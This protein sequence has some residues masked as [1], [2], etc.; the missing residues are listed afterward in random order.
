[1]MSYDIILI[2]ANSIG[3]AAMYQPNLARLAHDGESTAA[4]HGLPASVFKLMKRF[5]EAVP[6]ILW[7]GKARWRYDTYPDYKS[8][9]GSTPDKIA[10][11]EAYKRQ[12]PLLRQFFFDLGLPQVGHPDTEADDLAG[13]IARALVREHDD[14]HV[15][16]STTDSDWVQA[17]HARIHWFNTRDESITD[18]ARLASEEFKDGP[19][20]TPEQYLAAKCM[21]GDTSDTIDGVHGIGLKTGAKFLREHGSFEA[22]WAKADAG[23]AFK[24]AKL[25]SVITHDARA[26]YARNRS[27]MDW[28]KAPIP[29]D[30]GLACPAP[31]LASAI[32]MTERFG[33]KRVRESLATIVT[34][35]A[36]WQPL[37]W[38]IDVLLSH[39]HLE[40][41]EEAST[42]PTSS[43]P[44]F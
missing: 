6:V 43:R 17:L 3:Y 15:L 5:P 8:D 28:T 40:D 2:D 39:A 41:L 42:T 13:L 10:I 16:L 34:D 1:M 24:G 11:R 14:L 18:L 29:G 20:D 30:L 32:E 22:L 37:L 21:A 7:D 25:Q 38:R 9:R 19:F 35:R 33:L 12:A 44:R 31:D 4:L 27:I 36:L 23:E 26:L